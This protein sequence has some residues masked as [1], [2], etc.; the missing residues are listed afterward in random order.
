MDRT[1]P[2]ADQITH[3][4]DLREMAGLPRYFPDPAGEPRDSDVAQWMVAALRTHIDDQDAAARREGHDVPLRTTDFARRIPAGRYLVPGTNRHRVYEVAH[5]TGPDRGRVFLSWF[6][7]GK[8]V[9]DI[10]PRTRD[11]ILEALA[12]ASRL[13]ADLYES[14]YDP[15]ADQDGWER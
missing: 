10:Q 8:V 11:A 6:G 5:G 15:R 1:P 3:I 7:P 12:S 14:Q 2:T 4:Y 9:R 13:Y